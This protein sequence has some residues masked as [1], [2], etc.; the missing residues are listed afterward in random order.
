MRNISGN[1]PRFRLPRTA[2]ILSLSLLLTIASLPATAQRM[3]S[4]RAVRIRFAPGAMSAQVRGQMV[5]GRVGVFYVVKAKEGD[6]MIVN[7]ISTTSG[8]ETAG[9]IIAPSGEEDGQ[10]GGVVF[11]RQLTETGDYK[12][13]VTQNLMA[14]ERS[15]GSF[16]LEVL[17]TPSYVR[18]G[19]SR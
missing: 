18:E 5:K 14:G 11:N 3:A 8:F 15:S 19:E 16:I 9:E 7:I 4:S 2:L 6:H 13:R 10:H 12:I 17:V 1:A